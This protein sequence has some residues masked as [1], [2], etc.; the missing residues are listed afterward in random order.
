MPCIVVNCIGYRD[1][2]VYGFLNVM[3]VRHTHK[4]KQII[5]T[6]AKYILIIKHMEIK[7]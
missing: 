7:I 5:V 1:E 2:Y 3:Y 4:K 6:V